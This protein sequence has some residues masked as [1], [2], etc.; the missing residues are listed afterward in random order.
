MRTTT[1]RRAAALAGLLSI[2]MAVTATSQAP[3]A[4]PRRVQ[5]TLTSPVIGADGR[6]TFQLYAPKA[7]EV[8]LRSEGPAPFAN[9]PLAKGDSGVWKLTAQ[10][11]ADLYIYWYDVDGVPVVD[12]RNNRPRVLKQAAS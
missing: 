5:D 11:P 7:T 3:G 2:A 4:R 6:V 12:P 8:L 10:V 1:L 9:Q